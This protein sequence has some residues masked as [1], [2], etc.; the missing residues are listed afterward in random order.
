MPAVSN[1]IPNQNN[2]LN[3]EKWLSVICFCLNI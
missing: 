1:A 3:I 2:E